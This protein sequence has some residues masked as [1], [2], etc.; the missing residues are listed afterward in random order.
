MVTAD[1]KNNTSQIIL[2]AAKRLFYKKGINRTTLTDIARNSHIAHSLI[3]YYFKDKAG[4]IYAVM[5]REY[6]AMAR[7]ADN[8]A[9]SKQDSGIIWLYLFWYKYANE[10]EYARFFDEYLSFD[11][12]QDNRQSAISQFSILHDSIAGNRQAFAGINI[13]DYYD[14]CYRL[15]HHMILGIT[16]YHKTNNKNGSFLL[17]GRTMSVWFLLLNGRMDMDQSLD[18]I[19]NLEKKIISV[20]I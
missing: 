11:I 5:Q 13:N 6:Q 20:L 2:D 19:L 12:K 16:E 17:Y 9:E 10:K 15:Y 14:Y 1:E 7:K 8:I 3:S 4:V 18:Y